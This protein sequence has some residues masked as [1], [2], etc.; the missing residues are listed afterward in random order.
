M[1]FDDAG[2][3]DP[4]DR[5]RARVVDG[6][7]ERRLVG[8]IDDPSRHESVRRAPDRD[9]ARV[10]RVPDRSVL[11]PDRVPVRVAVYAVHV[12]RD[13]GLRRVRHCLLLRREEVR[14]GQLRR[15]CRHFLLGRNLG[16]SCTTF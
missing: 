12:H 5:A 14:R 11:G 1:Q 16:V 13:G 9:R 4:S 3:R 2:L 10:P 8:A 6:Q 15:H 7:L